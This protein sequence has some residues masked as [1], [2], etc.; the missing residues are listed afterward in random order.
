MV[1]VNQFT[2]D[3]GDTALLVLSFAGTLLEDPRASLTVLPRMLRVV[4][5]L[6]QGQQIFSLTLSYLVHH[7]MCC[8]MNGLWGLLLCSVELFS[9]AVFSSR[10]VHPIMVENA[11]HIALRFGDHLVDDCTHETRAHALEL[12]HTFGA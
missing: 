12:A 10:L 4:G 3:L 5:I 9:F 6:D 1:Y 8:S 7:A 2:F 11:E